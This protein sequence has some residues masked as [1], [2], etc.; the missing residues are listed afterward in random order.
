MSGA[1]TLSFF[2]K[3]RAIDSHLERGRGA[4]ATLVVQNGTLRVGDNLVAGSAFG[5]V[6]ALI[7]DTGKSIKEAGP[8]TPV[9]GTGLSHVRM[10]GGCVDVLGTAPG[11]RAKPG[12]RWRRQEHRREV[13]LL[14]VDVDAAFG[15]LILGQLAALDG[16]R[17]ALPNEEVSRQLLSALGGDA[18][19]AGCHTGAPRRVRASPMVLPMVS[20]GAK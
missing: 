10:A 1:A 9:V 11:A 2:G 14:D 5:K 13:R 7:D 17:P 3:G 12:Q 19:T 6:R 4:I 16:L 18:V 20:P 8:S 15:E